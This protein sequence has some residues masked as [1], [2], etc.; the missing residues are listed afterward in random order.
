MSILCVSQVAKTYGPLT[1]LNSASLL[2][3]HGDRTALVGSNGSGK[4]TLLRIITGELD[5]DS[6]A[7]VFQT[8]VTIGYLP[9]IP[10][11]ARDRSIAML[12]AD[13]VGDLRQIESRLRDVEA[14]LATNDS[15][16]D[17]DALL[18]EYGDLLDTF[19]RRGGWDLDH[20][21]ALVFSGL[22]IDHLD[23]DGAFDVLS[24]GE[25]ARVLLGILLLRQPDLLLLDEPTNHLDASALTWL[26]RY[27]A[28]YAGSMLLI[29]HDRRFLNATVTRI[30]DIDETSRTTTEYV[31]NFDAYHET[32]ERLRA[33]AILAWQEQ[34]DE[35]R[36]LR[37]QVKVTARQV[38]HNRAAKDPDKSLYNGKGARVEGAVSRNVRNAS[39][40]LERIDADPLPK[41]PIPLR[42]S[43]TFDPRALA[44]AAAV[45]V[46][47]VSHTFDGRQVLRDVSFTL[48]P[49]D[50]VVIIGPNGSG[51]STL[52]D[53]IAGELQPDAGSVRTAPGAL[54]GYLDQDGRALDGRLTVLDT[55]RQGLTGFQE[56]VINELMRFG[57]AQIEDLGKTVGVLSAG[58]RR[59]LQIARLI[60]GRANVLLLDE[61]TNHLSFDVLEAFEDAIDAFPG[62]IIAVS[63]DR[64][65]I[66]H[67]RGQQW[68]LNDG[69]LQTYPTS[70]ASNADTEARLL[71]MVRPVR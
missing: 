17:G 1:I 61:P 56:D 63:H 24:G 22:G 12:V 33:A 53:V 69:I 27:L 25:K 4:S 7:V 49:T 44:A 58:Q 31:G 57:L 45:E 48:G 23:R 64:W 29:S 20:R 14:L 2:I 42:I 67:F 55:W 66:D 13:A 5:A 8:G 52:L 32:R 21:M 71:N 39:E 19:E 37:R 35:I 59:K 51:K 28:T 9:Q 54:L 6:G 38:A 68:F 50:R 46:T 18:I 60:V 10:P 16:H 3:N 65:F 40:R 70:H 15:S 43:A 11:D 34:Q 41:P 30:V 62:P 26:E 36:D 47:N